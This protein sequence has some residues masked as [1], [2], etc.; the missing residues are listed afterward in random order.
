MKNIRKQFLSLI[1][2]MMM[3]LSCVATASAVD[4]ADNSADNDSIVLSSVNGDEG[5]M[6]SS[7]YQPIYEATQSTTGVTT[8]NDVSIKRGNEVLLSIASN[9]QVKVDIYQQ[10]F[11][12]NG[13]V[14]YEWAKG[15]YCANTN[16]VGR[17]YN[18]GSDYSGMYRFVI[19]PTS[20][21]SYT[22]ALGLR[23]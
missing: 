5:I 12:S 7:V 14:K 4:V 16:N 3:L 8:I 13:Q 23:Y 18:L 22:L 6:P 9:V 2:A 17:T 20:S 19:A 21:G 11:L 10:V 1:M 15:F